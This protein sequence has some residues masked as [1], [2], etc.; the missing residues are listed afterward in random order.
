MTGTELYESEEDVDE[1]EAMEEDDQ[2]EAA[3]EE[4]EEEEYDIPA[5][6]AKKRK[7]SGASVPPSPSKNTV[8]VKQEPI[9]FGTPKKVKS[10]A[11]PKTPSGN[12]EVVPPTS[13]ERHSLL[14]RR[15]MLI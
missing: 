5:P 8:R 2:P 13:R 14:L 15:D 9:S 4:E 7:I 10:M 3:E 11:A 1:D 12:G 6:K